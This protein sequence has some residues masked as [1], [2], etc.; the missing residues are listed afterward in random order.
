MCGTA[1]D[2][3]HLCFHHAPG[4]EFGNG[5]LGKAHFLEHLA[6]LLTQERGRSTRHH[7]SVAKPHIVPGHPHQPDDGVA[8]CGNHIVGRGVQIIEKDLTVSRHGRGTRNTGLVQARQAL[9]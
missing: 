5:W 7:C 2:H 6:R 1:H 9:M 3:W 8:M 4:I